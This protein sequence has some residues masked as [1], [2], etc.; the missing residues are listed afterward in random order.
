[1]GNRLFKIGCVAV[2][3][4][5]HGYRAVIEHARRRRLDAL[6]RRTSENGMWHLSEC[7]GFL[8]RHRQHGTGLPGDGVVDVLD[9]ATQLGPPDGRMCF[10]LDG[11]RVVCLGARKKSSRRA[12]PGCGG[13]AR[14]SKCLLLGLWHSKQNSRHAGPLQA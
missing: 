11:V 7:P 3:F 4:L 5:A 14:S 10:L 6:R 8:N 9:G 13:A 1:M 12:A 2:V